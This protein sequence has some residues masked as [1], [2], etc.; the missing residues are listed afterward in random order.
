[1]GAA[2]KA[3]ATT[4]AGA[5]AGGFVGVGGAVYVGVLKNDVNAQIG[6]S[7]RVAARNDVE[8]NALGI[9]DVDGFVVSAAGGFVGV[10]A[11]VQVWS[12]GEQLQRSYSDAS[13]NSEDSLEK[14]RVRWTPTAS[15]VDTLNDT[16][17]V[18]DLRDLKTGEKVKYRKGA[19]ENVGI[20]GL[21]DGQDYYVRLESGRVA[22]Y[23]TKQ[24]A[25]NGGAFGR[26]DLQGIGTGEHHSLTQSTDADAAQQGEN[27]AAEV[28]GQLD[29]FDAQVSDA[30]RNDG[31]ASSTER[32]AFYASRGS[33]D[34][35]TS[36]PSSKSVTRGRSSTS[37]RNGSRS[38]RG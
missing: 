16:I 34:L 20:T 36:R 33:N 25:T 1:M 29:V 15:N 35:E 32:L 19:A 11:S 24:Q 14:Q 5:I 6:S 18:G 26:A 37:P 2:N 4:F 31:N 30:E 8:V 9:K 27:A 13:G 23:D 22:L 17:D 7:A 3:H 21:N 12:V 38:S 28:S 10:G